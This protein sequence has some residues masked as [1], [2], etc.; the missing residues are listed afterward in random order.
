MKPF[1]SAVLSLLSLVALISWSPFDSA[2]QAK[3][4]P[5][6]VILVADDLG[7]HDV[8]YHGSEVRTPHLDKLARAGIRLERHY[9]Y[10]TCSP[11]RACLLTGRNASRFGIQDAISGRSTLSLPLGVSTLPGVLQSQGYV[12]ALC[13]KWHLGLRPKVGPRQFGFDQTYGYLHGQLDAYSHRYKNGDR[14]WHRND[15]FTDE[16]GH[17]TDLIADEAVRFVSAKRTKPFF[18]Y[19]A[20]S[21]PHVPLQEEER[22]LAPYRDTITDPSRRLFAASVTHLDD[23]VGRIVAALDKSGR[24]RDTLILFTSDNG[25]QRDH[26]S[27][28]DYQGKYGPYPVLGDN[29]PWRGWKGELYEGGVRVPA[30][31]YWPGR[32]R[33]GELR[34]T[35]SC[36]DW[37]PTLTRLA[38][39]RSVTADK[40]DGRDVWPLLTGE[41]P[42]SPVLPL[43]WHTGDAE[44]VLDGDWKL[45]VP[46]RMPQREELYNLAD[47]PTEK[48]NQAADNP[49]KAEALRRILASQ[50]SH[51]R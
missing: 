1:R 22:W 31:V 13:G 42:K 41:G 35:V 46:Q 40:L 18:L 32:L 45:I 19:V 21:A 25:G 6:F 3:D 44:A 26:A 37:F 28:T 20:F 48:K 11:T 16:K 36:L 5:N 14:T 47:D 30:L 4:L 38:G 2:A 49:L 39:L 27:R 50:K 23:A 17:A 33:S 51:D 10:P 8:G 29:R 24:L 7:W 15:Q 9:V 43:Y 12:T 34:E